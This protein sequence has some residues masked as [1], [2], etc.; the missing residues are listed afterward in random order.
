[1][2]TNGAAQEPD[3]LEVSPAPDADQEVQADNKASMKGQAVVERR[4]YQ[5]G[6]LGAGQRMPDEDIS[7]PDWSH[8]VGFK[9]P[10][11]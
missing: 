9:A 1:M 11:I 8:V 6:N 5:G 10:F 2:L 3:L 7:Q 4:R